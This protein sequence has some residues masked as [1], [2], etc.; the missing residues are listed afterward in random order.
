MAAGLLL[1][2]SVIVNSGGTLKNV[3]VWVKRGLTGWR[4]PV[5][6]E[7]ANLEQKGC[8]FVPHVLGV[9]AKQKILIRNRDPL[10]HNL[11]SYCKRN[12][13][14]NFGQPNASAED[15]TSF[16]NPEVMVN[17]KCDLHGWMNSYIGVLAHPFF[18]VTGDDGSFALSNLPPGDYTIE[19]WHEV[20]GTKT[21]RVTLSDK[22]S[23]KLEIGFDGA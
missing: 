14:F 12:R 5:P 13:S 2:E 18:A 19:A 17:L 4:F 16:R 23:R 3:F 21:V 9:Q 6:T 8:V 7:P 11:H 10:L 22:E 1:D 20:Y 15:T